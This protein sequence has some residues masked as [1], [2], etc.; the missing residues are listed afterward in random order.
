M[1]RIVIMAKVPIAGSVKTRLAPALGEQ[2]AADLALRMLHHCIETALGAKAG[3]VELCLAAHSTQA[4]FQQAIK[5]RWP[6]LQFSDQGEGDLGERM[7]RIVKR[8]TQ[9]GQ[10]VILLGTDCPDITSLTLQAAAKAL[11]QNACAIVPTFDGGYCLIAL[12]QH[13]P[14]LFSNIAWSTNSV[15]AST[16][17]A[18]RQLHWQVATLPMLHDIDE[19]S[20]LQYLPETWQA[21]L[22]PSVN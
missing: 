8:V 4:D 10:P 5:A 11:Q 12:R 7:S 3:E 18:L 19:P 1:T 22:P 20:D 17:A 21:A 13:H 15:Y 6:S 9:S 2:G 14:S 16:L